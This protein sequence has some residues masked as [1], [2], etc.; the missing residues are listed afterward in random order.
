MD[1]RIIFAALVALALSPSA[2]A[3]EK[4][5]P[6]AS[7]RESAM[8]F[9][10]HLR[11][12]LSQSAVQGERKKNRAG[13]VA[14]VRGADQSSS[15]ADPNEPV[16][17]GDVRS[18]KG[19]A[20]MAEDAEF[21]AAVDLVLAGKNSEGV[22]ALEEFKVRHPKSHNLASVQQAIDQANSLGA[23]KAAVTVPSSSPAPAAAPKADA[24]K[25]EPAK[26]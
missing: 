12:A 21:A 22:K 7:V 19:K 2:R 26:N 17:K 15:L 18:K 3:D 16:L 8:T 23:D 14:A 20:A 5:V 24:A 4:P 25:A 10:R 1:S 11:E 9:F 13:S 6:A